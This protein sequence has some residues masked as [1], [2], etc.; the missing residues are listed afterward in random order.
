MDNDLDDGTPTLQDKIKEKQKMQFNINRD[1][2]KDDR[3]AN[4]VNV[5]N[6][7]LKE[8]DDEEDN[9][10]NDIRI[11]LRER[12]DEE[13]NKNNDIVINQKKN[14]NYKLR[15]RDNDVPNINLAN[16]DSVPDINTIER[17]V[18][19]N[20]SNRRNILINNPQE[21]SENRKLNI[22]I[23]SIRIEQKKKRLKYC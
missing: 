4:I 23:N 12:N 8:R 18:D 21:E 22:R 1:I 6:I 10:I 11:C 13:D 17:I 19:V 16:N 3:E 15:M 2:I 9:K 20:R 14:D 7:C 5:P